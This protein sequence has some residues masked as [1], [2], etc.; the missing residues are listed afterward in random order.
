MADTLT[1][2]AITVLDLTDDAKWRVIELDEPNPDIERESR[3]NCGGGTRLVKRQ[4]KSQTI[5]LKVYFRGAD[6]DTA[7]NNRDSFINALL[8]AVAYQTGDTGSAFYVAAATYLIRSIGNQT[9]VDIWTVLDYDARR[10]R[11]AWD[12]DKKVG[13]FI[14]LICYPGQLLPPG[15]P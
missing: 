6:A 13:F 4:L 15:V 14:D 7:M 9:P 3:T 2:G 12:V 1:L 5:P 11:K 8:T 10:I